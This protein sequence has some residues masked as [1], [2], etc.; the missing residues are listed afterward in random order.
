MWNRTN[1]EFT[2]GSWFKGRIF[3]DRSDLSPD[4]RHMI[5]FAMGGVSWAIPATGGSGL[6]S[7]GYLRLKPRRFGDRAIRGAKEECSHPIV[8][9]G[10]KQTRTHFSFMIIWVFVVSRV[11][12]VSRR[13]SGTVGCQERLPAR[14]SSSRRRFVTGGFFGRLDGK[15]D[16]NSINPANASWY[17]RIGN[18]RSGIGIDLYGPMAVVC[19]RLQ[20]ERTSSVLSILCMIS[21]AWYPSSLTSSLNEGNYPCDRRTMT[22]QIAHD[23][24]DNHRLKP[25]HFTG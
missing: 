3:A 21:T 22:I 1:D 4:G 12:L 10:S 20:L 18:G 19:E 2:P 25:V 7:R 13:W 14:V 17:F 24:A 23:L 15:A 16:T 9:S 5:Y 8:H 6:R 11:V